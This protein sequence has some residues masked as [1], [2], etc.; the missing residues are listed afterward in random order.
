MIDEGAVAYLYKPIDVGELERTV[1]AVFTG[2]PLSDGEEFV[3]SPDENLD[4]N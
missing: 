3:V 2:E 1:R 4:S